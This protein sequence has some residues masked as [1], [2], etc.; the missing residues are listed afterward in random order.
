MT[1]ERAVQRLTS[2]LAHAWR[3]ADRGELAPGRFA[4]LVI[5][6]PDTIS[7]GEEVWVED[8]PGGNGR[9]VRHPTG[10]DQVIVN[11]EL[12]VDQGRYSASRPGCLI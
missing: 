4:D 3:I 5:F 11:G 1:L 12:L 10:V 8:I 6:D 2:D 9:Y 7:R